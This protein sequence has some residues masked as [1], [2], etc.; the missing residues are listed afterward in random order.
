VVDGEC[1]GC[2]CKQKRLGGPQGEGEGEMNVT[3]GVPG[4]S[5][6]ANLPWAVLCPE[7]TEYWG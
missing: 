7:S 2:V 5:D 1:T 4:L 6:A 3:A